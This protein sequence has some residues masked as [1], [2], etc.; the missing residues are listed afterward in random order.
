MI[1][2]ATLRLAIE[3]NSSALR[4]VWGRIDGKVTDLIPEQEAPHPTTLRVHFV[5]SPIKNPAAVPAD[6]TVPPSYTVPI[7]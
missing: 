7:I 2:L 4:E 3:G 5:D 1:I 6:Y